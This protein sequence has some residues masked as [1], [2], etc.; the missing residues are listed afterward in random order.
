MND[1]Q[2]LYQSIILEHNRNPQNFGEL[3]DASCSAVGYNA[4]C[5]DDIRLFLKFDGDVI[6]DIRFF[7]EGCAISRASASLLTIAVK[8]Q[9][10]DHAQEITK[11]MLD[12]LGSQREIH[13]IPSRLGAR[14]ALLGVRK[15]PMRIKCATL[16]WHALVD[17]LSA[18]KP[19]K[20]NGNVAH[21]SIACCRERN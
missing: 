1:L 19:N 20:L 12:L 5:G 2:E 6:E 17:A 18:K 16:P 14:M 7:G 3:P 10:K 21:S 15:F 8:N 4:S 11:E 9:R 13:D